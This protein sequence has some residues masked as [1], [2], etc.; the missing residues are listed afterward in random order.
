MTLLDKNKVSDASQTNAE[1]VLVLG[2]HP[3]HAGIGD[4]VYTVYAHFARHF[5][6]RA[7]E[8]LAP[9]AFN[10]IID[11]F[12][13]PHYV[14]YL[15][16]TKRRHP[17]TK[18]AVVAT[19]FYTPLPAAILGIQGT[20]NFFGGRSDWLALGGQVLHQL[21]LAQK[22]HSYM[23]RRFLGFLEAMEVADIILSVHPEILASLE[24]LYQ[25]AKQMRC[26]AANLYP[27]IDLDSRDRMHRLRT[28]PFGFALTGSLTAYRAR[29]GAR[30]RQA[31]TMAGYNAAVYREIPFSPAEKLSLKT[32]P[33]EVP[34]YLFNFNPPQQAR[35]AFSSPMR[36]LRAALLGQIPVVTK[37]FGDHE[38]ESI[39]LLW[40]PSVENAQHFWCDGTIGRETLIER[41][42]DS[43]ADYNRVAE[44]KNKALTKAC[45][46][47]GIG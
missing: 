5:R 40:E 21:R 20:F 41:F 31:F 7:Q 38:I 28:L 24:L 34:E 9:D 45:V 11:E 8:A 19:E 42:A 44:E 29:A 22:P 3:S 12:T 47:A 14:E 25:R 33:T 18:Y 32:Y 10:I 1:C 27:T 26:P 39:A 16:E 37:V 6:V 13:N 43:V 46:A 15:R 2:N 30:L 23:H 17:R 4:I 36:M 35:W